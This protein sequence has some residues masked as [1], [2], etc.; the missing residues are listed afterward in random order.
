MYVQTASNRN[1]PNLLF[2]NQFLNIWLY[3]HDIKLTIDWKWIAKR[4]AWTLI[5]II[6]IWI[7]TWFI[8]NFELLISVGKEENKKRVWNSNCRVYIWDLVKL[9]LIWWFHFRLYT[10]IITAQLT[11]KILITSKSGQKWPKFLL[12][13]SR[14]CL[15]TL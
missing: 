8:T 2:L 11:P 5:N 10:I 12:L 9:N 14:L 6:R 3:F 7:C 1:D 4:R 13:L 15:N